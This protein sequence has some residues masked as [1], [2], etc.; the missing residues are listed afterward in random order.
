MS[1]FEAREHL[2][3]Y[4]DGDLSGEMLTRM[5]EALATDAVLRAD[6][7]ELRDM[8]DG[9][10]SLPR[11]EAPEGLFSAVMAGVAA[12]PIPVSPDLA[13][14]ST[15]L[16]PP[17]PRVVQPPP[18]AP[19]FWE[20]VLNLSW[21]LKGPALSAAA[22]LLVVGVVFVGS[23]ERNPSAPP[24]P[25]ALRGVPATAESAPVPSGVLSGDA[26]MEGDA[27]AD[28]GLDLET[29]REAI[30]F[31]PVV[32]DAP[33]PLMAEAEPTVLAGG[34]RPD[35]PPPVS[36]PVPARFTPPESAVGP[37]GVYEAE[38]E[39]EGIAVADSSDPAAGSGPRL[40][41]DV[42]EGEVNL[43]AT[44]DF[45]GAAAF[46]P[47]EATVT[48]AEEQRR[49][50][51]VDRE[52]AAADLTMDGEPL[53]D[54]LD[55]PADDDI[56]ASGRMASVSELR[57][58][59]GSSVPKGKAGGPVSLDEVTFTGV[60][61]SGT[62]AVSDR[63]A[64]DQ[65]VETL[66]D[67]GWTASVAAEQATLLVLDI[68]V[69]SSSFDELRRVLAARGSLSLGGAPTASDGQVQLRLSVAWGG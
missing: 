9:L 45:D 33:A 66:R 10:G 69:P 2:S 25:V 43:A 8:I 40:A 13:A 58:S 24:A 65:L 31:A 3:A 59:T 20:S 55:P 15:E 28:L 50:R 46:A 19:G 36:G 52:A 5:E 64:A 62:L 57:P 53:E 32:D 38:W 56:V 42:A 63:A 1:N 27:V 48:G 11:I 51:G 21:W 61:S 4:L 68:R 67:R 6:L 7:D 60:G 44:D 14:E 35:A 37:E 17:A 29:S 18:A 30:E 47:D 23:S 22:A 54:W 26:L 12:L 16:A 39:D 41:A 49:A 34:A